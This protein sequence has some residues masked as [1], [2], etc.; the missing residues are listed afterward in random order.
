MSVSPFMLRWLSLAHD[1]YGDREDVAGVSLSGG[2]QLKAHNT[3]DLLFSDSTA[4]MYVC[5]GTWGF[6]P[7]PSFWNL[8]QDWYHNLLD[9]G[10]VPFMTPPSTCFGESCRHKSRHSNHFDTSTIAATASSLAPAADFEPLDP[11]QP[12]KPPV[13]HPYVEGAFPT[14]WYKD[15]EKA[16]TT[17][18]MWEMWFIYFASL[19]NRYTVY[20]YLNAAFL[21]ERDLSDFVDPSSRSFFHSLSFSHLCLAINRMEAGLHFKVSSPS[22]SCQLLHAWSPSFNILPS[23]LKKIDWNGEVVAVE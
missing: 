1:K 2:D 5:V 17:D 21:D 4:L 23:K 7:H 22:T 16:G 6:S 9:R 18:S 20:P 11:F 14:Q 8:F 13:F 3:G 12:T 10:L 15:F 19:Y